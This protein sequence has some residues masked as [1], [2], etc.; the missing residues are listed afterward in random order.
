MLK[1]D[2]NLNSKIISLPKHL[3]YT[4]K[5]YLFGI[6]LFTCFR[7]LLFLNHIPEVKTEYISTIVFGFLKGLQ[8][9]TVISCYILFIPFILFSVNQFL[10]LNRIN[11]IAKV[12]ILFLYTIAFVISACDIPF[13]NHF[14][15]RLNTSIFLWTNNTDFS[16]KMIF[17]EI[18]FFIYLIPLVCFIVC[19]YIYE[20]RVFKILIPNKPQNIFK[21]ILLTVFVMAI[22]VLGMRGRLAK[23][24]PIRTGSSYYCENP[25]LNKL[26]L[27][28][29]FTL[30]S[31]LINDLKHDA[32]DIMLTDNETALSYARQILQSNDSIGITRIDKM[33]HN[34]TK[35]NVV[36]VIMES[37]CEF[38]RG[39]YNGPINKT[40]NLNRIEKESISFTK[41]F[42]T[43]IH[44][45]NGIY[46]TLYSM[47]AIFKQKPLDLYINTKHYSLPHILAENGYQNMYFTTHDS[48]FDNVAGFLMANGFHKIISEKDYPLKEI[49][50]TLG[51]PDHFL[52]EYA[53]NELSIDN[54]KPF[55]A[56]IMT[57]SLH[58]PYIIP[59]D[60]S[61]RPKSKK[62]EEQIIEYA[63]WSIMHFIEI[64]KTKKWF[65]NTIF[66]F[67]ADH[68]LSFGHTYDLPLSG[69]YIPFFIYSPSNLVAEQKNQLASQMDVGPTLLHLLNIEFENNTLGINLFEQ[70]HSCVFFCA[71]DRLG[72]IDKNYYWLQRNDGR[73]SLYQHNNLDWTERIDSNK[74]K[75]NSL[76][77]H[78]INMLQSAQ[79]LY[80]NNLLGKRNYKSQ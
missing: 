62:T 73:E 67:I 50:S 56:A 51:V 38:K 15:T 13:F 72:C 71:D 60:I 49:K 54:S 63:D 34:A 57:G 5:I 29:S 64:A 45:F 39:K 22:L 2:T 24:S 14:N 70:E 27:N 75:A 31:S 55:F 79:Y 36:I 76:K 21:S 69:H 41:S 11:K 43:G 33:Q 66:I 58:K 40:P 23:K 12:L 3:V 47:P 6:L 17:Q 25:F 48:E 77:V 19:F 32:K 52:F 4:I 44:T 37:M 20:R 18:T 46:S 80:N 30:L 42:S 8:F 9:D 26:G 35:K 53:I 16:L 74:T 28:P 59:E 7:F 65:D 10:N 61:F 68:G 1:I 78:A